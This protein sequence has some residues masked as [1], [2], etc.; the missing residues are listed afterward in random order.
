[1][2]K[3]S[4]YKA[5]KTEYNGIKYD[6]KKEAN[7]AK[8]LDTRLNLF[9]NILHL[10]RQVK[11]EW[12]EKHCLGDSIIEFKRSYIADFTYLDLETSENMIIDVK[13]YKTAEY[14]KKKK[15]VEHLFGIKITEV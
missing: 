11:Y 1:M 3:K 9:K 5:V 4:K 7:Y 2:I 15:I 10:K 12:I 6:S 14:K 8:K 13:D